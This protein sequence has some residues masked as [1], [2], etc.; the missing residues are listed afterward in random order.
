MLYVYLHKR[1]TFGVVFSSVALI[2]VSPV[3]MY[4]YM[5]SQSLHFGAVFTPFS[6]VLYHMPIR[7]IALFVSHLKYFLF[8]TQGSRTCFLNYYCTLQVCIDFCFSVLFVCG[9]GFRGLEKVLCLLLEVG[10]G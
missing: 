5:F 2:I 3:H 8:F 4:I 9:G 6:L 1:F 10:F 7:T